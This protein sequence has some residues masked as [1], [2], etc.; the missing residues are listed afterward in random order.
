[1]IVGND[2]SRSIVVAAAFLLAC[3]WETFGQ[4]PLTAF[5]RTSDMPVGRSVEGLLTGDFN[6][7]GLMDV[8][9]YGSHHLTILYSSADNSFRSP[10][11]IRLPEPVEKMLSG[12][13]NRDGT[14]DIAMFSLTPRRLRIYLGRSDTLQLRWLEPIS[15]TAEHALVYDL[16]GD[17]NPDILLY[18]KK[19]LGVTVYLGNGDGTFRP[20]LEI[21]SDYSFSTLRA[22]DLNADR[23][24]DLVGF[25]WVKN[26][27]LVFSGIGRLRFGI[28]S[29]VSLI[30]EPIDLALDHLD[31]DANIDLVTVHRD[32][33]QLRLYRGDGLGMFELYQTIALPS[34]PR[35]L[36][37]RDVN[38][39]A[40]P[41]V[42]VFSEIGGSFLVFLNDGVG[43][44]NRPLV[45]AAGSLPTDIAFY[46]NRPTALP[47]AL[48][49]EKEQRVLRTYHNAA[50]TVSSESEYTY[51]LGL[52]P[53]GIAL[54]D[55]NQNG[56]QDII[57]INRGSENASVLLNQ[58]G[59]RFLG[60]IAIGA[61]PLG[62]AVYPLRKNDS[63]LYLFTTHSSID[64][65]IA[66]EVN[67]PSFESVSFSLPTVR[68]PEVLRAQ[69]HERTGYFSLFV[70]GKDESSSS[71]SIS[72]I[73]RLDRTRF[74][75]QPYFAQPGVDILAADLCD[76][77]GDGILDVVYATRDKDRDR[78]QVFTARGKRGGGFSPPHLSFA[79]PDTAV[80]EISLWTMD[81]NEDSRP[82]LLSQM[83]S[84]DNWLA[85]ALGRNDSAF[86][87]VH[88]RF[89]RVLIR[90]R[91]DIKLADIDGDGIQDLVIANS[92]T[93]TI[94]VFLGR[95]GGSFSSPKRLLSFPGTSGFAVSDFNGDGIPDYAVV[96][97]V[98][99]QLR[100]FW[101]R[102]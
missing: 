51:A 101:G 7:D 59:G 56:L 4:R 43:T 11:L 68:S 91:D 57:V 22:I 69:V 78:I 73:E 98:S 76:I 85:L 6:G 29:A 19:S 71:V 63:T 1:M 8:A 100:L 36:L 48:V 30:S 25:D 15:S 93:K 65:V 41:D 28:P 18:G 53:Q 75:E 80:A 81:L 24:A 50:D 97:S 40:Y 89:P 79:L 3:S 87:P 32:P 83:R 92:H 45:Y 17:R 13:F 2:T 77:N 33:Q 23:I 70:Q 94:Q 88:Q 52:K 72:R 14:D 21:L 58:G 95:G 35:K 49:L 55:V 86:A 16:N 96:Y 10:T 26:E 64:K 84:K 67:Y 38:G 31:E 102:E 46:Q 60:Q 12:D 37:T 54:F 5:G 20:P 62:E 39:D 27:L 99:G 90:A 9:S 66:T 34:V 44:V 74:V 61:G 42:T 47:N 82:D